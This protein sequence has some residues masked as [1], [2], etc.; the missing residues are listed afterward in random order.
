MNKILTAMTIAAAFSLPT[1][2][3][4]ANCPDD[5]PPV[6]EVTAQ[7]VEKQIWHWNTNPEAYQPDE[8]C[9]DCQDYRIVTDHALVSAPDATKQ[10]R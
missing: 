10:K 7:V 1:A 3:L 4:Y 8:F 2:S 5:A 6:T 9:I